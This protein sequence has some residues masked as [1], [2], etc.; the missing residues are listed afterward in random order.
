M[1]P[2]SSTSP[3]EATASDDT[4]M[5]ACIDACQS[6]HAECL[7]TIQHCLGLG[8][9]HASLEHISLMASCADICATSADTM[10]L[11]AAVHAH[12]CG[13]CA[14][15]CRQCAKSCR[16]IGQEPQLLRCA[17][18]CDRCADECERMS[19]G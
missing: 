2:T 4:A 10:L 14:A 17:E 18:Q 16:S 9:A 13:A 7:R 8:G 19:A 11:G 12:T 3:R 1:T 6:C 15:V 5:Q